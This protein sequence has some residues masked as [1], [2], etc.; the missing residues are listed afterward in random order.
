MGSLRGARGYETVRQLVADPH[1]MQ[2]PASIELVGCLALTLNVGA[3][4]IAPSL[5]LSGKVK[6][7]GW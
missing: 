4:L 5:V 1:T 2:G 3:G 7:A 6:I